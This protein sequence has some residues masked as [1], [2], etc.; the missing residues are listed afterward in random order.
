MQKLHRLLAQVPAVRGTV[1]PL[2]SKVHFFGGEATGNGP[3]RAGDWIKILGRDPQDVG[4]LTVGQAEEATN[5]VRVGPCGGF[6]AL[7]LPPGHWVADDGS[8]QN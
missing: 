6:R 1:L 8:I 5:H 4:G 2:G 7:E 3:C